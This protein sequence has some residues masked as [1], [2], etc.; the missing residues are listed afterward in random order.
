M[1]A[2]LPKFPNMRKVER[3]FRLVLDGGVPINQ[4]AIPAVGSL[5]TRAASIETNIGSLQSAVLSS[6]S[7]GSAPPVATAG[8][9]RIAYF[10]DGASGA[11]TMA[12]CNSV[13][14]LRIDNLEAIDAG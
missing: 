6:Y 9:G 4:A 3:F 14:W 10:T 5:Q 12:F 7:V 1:A 13:S 2:L 11:A 8:I